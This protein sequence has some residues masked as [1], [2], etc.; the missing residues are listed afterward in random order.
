[1]FVLNNKVHF[2]GL[3]YCNPVLL[4]GM[5][6]LEK[7]IRIPNIRIIGF[8]FKLRITKIR[9]SDLIFEYIRISELIF[10]YIRISEYCF[11]VNF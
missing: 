6:F 10:E 7:N 2:G 3:K 11:I 1:M 4:L 9:I 8:F 5:G